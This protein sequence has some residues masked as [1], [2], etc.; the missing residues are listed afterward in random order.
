MD[1]TLKGGKVQ[2]SLDGIIQNTD[3]IQRDAEDQQFL[4]CKESLTKV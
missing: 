3:Q 4:T 2:I 1:T